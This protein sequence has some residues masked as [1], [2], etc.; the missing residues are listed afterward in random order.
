MLHMAKES[1]FGAP[2][3][4]LNLQLHSEKSK[5]AGFAKFG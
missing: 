5:H 1:H 3:T 4:L 2:F